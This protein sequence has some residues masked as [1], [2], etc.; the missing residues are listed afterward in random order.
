MKKITVKDLIRSFI[1]PPCVFY[2]DKTRDMKQFKSDF[3]FRMLMYTDGLIATY[4]EYIKSSSW[5]VDDTL[6]ITH[7]RCDFDFMTKFSQIVS[8]AVASGKFDELKYSKITHEF[9]DCILFCGDKFRV[10]LM[11]AYCI[12]K[13]PKLQ[14]IIND[15]SPNL[16]YFLDL[17]KSKFDKINFHCILQDIYPHE[18][19]VVLKTLTCEYFTMEKY[20]HKKMF[21]T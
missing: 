3:I 18:L 12:Y 4:S 15:A 16:P 1:P 7:R 20:S 6:N 5:G 19:V 13:I 14:I 17:C 8:Q 9:V 10:I 11:F 21:I 2:V